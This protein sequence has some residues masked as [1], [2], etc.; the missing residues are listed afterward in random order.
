MLFRSPQNPKTP[1][2]R[3]ICFKLKSYSPV[4]CFYLMLLMISLVNCWVVAVPPKSGVST[5]PS[6]ILLNTPS[7]IASAKYGKFRYLSIIQLANTKA[8]GLGSLEFKRPFPEHLAPCSNMPS[9]WPILAPG[10]I[11]A[12]PTSP[13]ATFPIIDP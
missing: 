1:K 12:P 11:P 5:F 4:H 2:P 7:W 9:S 13:A 6:L 3:A 8:V 10:A